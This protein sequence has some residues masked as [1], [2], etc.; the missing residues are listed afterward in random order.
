MNDTQTTPSRA[1][2]PDSDK[3]DLS[4]LFADADKWQEDVAWITQVYPRVTEWNAL[5][6]SFQQ[7]LPNVSTKEWQPAK[8][9]FNMQVQLK[10]A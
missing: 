1:D 4:H 5:M 8:L 9:A 2:L 10:S 3:W 7:P 6:A